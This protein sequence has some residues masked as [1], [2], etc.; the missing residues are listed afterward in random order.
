MAGVQSSAL[1]RYLR[2]I[3]AAGDAE[4]T[5]DG[6]LLAQFLAR[7]DEAAFE[8]LLRRHGPMVL[9][10]CRRVLGNVHDAEDAFQATFLVL[11]RKAAS[12]GKPECV[13]SWLYRV[14]YRTALRAKREAA[15]RHGHERSLTALPAGDTID[16]L[17]WQELRPILDEEVNRLAEKYRG[18][19]VLC[20]LEEKTYAEAAKALGLAAGTVSSRLARARDM[21]RKRLSRR[22]LAL[23]SGLLTS[24]L[25]RNALAAAVPA[26]LAETT[27]KAAVLTAAGTVAADLVS[28]SA[29]ALTEEVPRAMLMTRLRMT[30]CV[31]LVVGLLGTGAGAL[32]HRV[33]AARQ[34]NAPPAPPKQ[35]NAPPAPP[36]EA[37]KPQ[38]D[39]KRA[40]EKAF[41]NEFGYSWL[42]APQKFPQGLVPGS[43]SLS[44]FQGVVY[45]LAEGK[46]GEVLIA[47]AHGDQGG[48]EGRTYRPVAFDGE[49]GVSMALYVFDQ[50]SLPANR[51]RYLGIEVLT[52]E[53]RQAIAAR[54]LERAKAAGVEV[55]PPSRLGEPYDFA[56]TTLDGK[57]VRARDLR[58]KVVLID[59]W[60][61][62]CS[63]CMEKMPNLRSLY[64]KRHREGFEILGVS[65]DLDAAKVKRV[66]KEQG[67]TW[68][69]VLVPADE[70]RRALWRDA[71][72]LAIIPRLL[73]IDR[74]GILR[75]DCGPDQLE[76]EIAR[77]LD[78]PAETPPRKPK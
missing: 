41:E 37:A 50:R 49:R 7:H 63:P 46:N 2:K 76:E 67:L 36:R 60:S 62:T 51:L 30:M 5:S 15:R 48:K 77:L 52:P 17:A 43:Y 44:A 34:A 21:L 58:G 1:V 74:E 11:A 54:A 38:G 20:Y 35:A 23:S 56:L 65:F 69:Q 9:G 64:E 4:G 19:V 73:L 16:D 26:P 10:I 25:A 47:L 40:P 72:D 12:I 53:G 32:S 8:A 27:T 61:T 14:A 70:K 24:L 55:L 29:T 42:W 39:R 68:P 78:R 6:Q 75:A 71:A 28:A 66:C 45:T 31:L 3:A 59:C 18:P 57:K 33:L 22:G 13:G